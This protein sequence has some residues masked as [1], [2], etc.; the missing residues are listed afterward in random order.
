MK[1]LSIRMRI[2]SSE[3]TIDSNS[4]HQKM[5]EAEEVLIW[6][7]LDC[8]TWIHKL[9]I[10]I[11]RFCFCKQFH[12]LITLYVL[13]VHVSM[14]CRKPQNNFPLLIETFLF[15]CLFYFYLT[16]YIKSYND[17]HF[18]LRKGGSEKSKANNIATF[19]VANFKVKYWFS[20]FSSL[21]RNASRHPLAVPREK[22][23]LCE[24]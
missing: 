16:V 9:Y 15:I 21:P 14:P 1:I 11:F 6:Y 22:N 20:S 2:C 5:P 12:Q 8:F 23:Y 24:I 7:K 18:C 4:S 19:K 10:H 17:N 3:L 13:L